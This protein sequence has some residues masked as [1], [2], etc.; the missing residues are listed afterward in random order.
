MCFFDRKLRFDHDPIKS[1]VIVLLFQVESLGISISYLSPV[2]PVGFKR[3]SPPAPV[4]FKLRSGLT[5]DH[6]KPSLIWKKIT[7]SKLGFMVATDEL[8][9]L[10]N[11]DPQIS[12][13]FNWNE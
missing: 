5:E 6:R 1:F 9:C 12:M 2:A 3:G 13:F 10:K 7:K 8:L 11:V 4:G